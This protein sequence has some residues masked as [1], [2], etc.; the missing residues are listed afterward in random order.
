MVGYWWASNVNVYAAPARQTRNTFTVASLQPDYTFISCLSCELL[1]S[2]S[3][4][5]S[6]TVFLCHFFGMSMKVKSCCLSSVMDHD[7]M[8]ELR[9]GM[10]GLL[11]VCESDSERDRGV[12]WGER[13][14]STD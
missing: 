4:T 7:K 13:E 12:K 8:R 3:V 9:G 10:A 2:V 14:I 11:L 6:H 5:H 1:V